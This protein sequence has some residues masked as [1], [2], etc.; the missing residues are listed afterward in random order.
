MAIAILSKYKIE[1]FLERPREKRVEKSRESLKKSYLRNTQSFSHLRSGRYPTRFPGDVSNKIAPIPD[2]IETEKRE[3][4]S[5]IDQLE[6]KPWKGAK[7]NT[8]H[9]SLARAFYYELQ[10]A[11]ILWN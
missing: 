11:S 8:F 9:F 2:F 5:K 7:K 3:R 6:D 10:W 1:K 4:H